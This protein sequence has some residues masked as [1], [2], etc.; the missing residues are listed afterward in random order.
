MDS[1]LCPTSGMYVYMWGHAVLQQRY[2]IM[3][4]SGRFFVCHAAH[5]VTS[6]VVL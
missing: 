5:T 3:T 1:R 6:L 2:N 4:G